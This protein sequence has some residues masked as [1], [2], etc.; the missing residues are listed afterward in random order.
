MTLAPAHPLDALAAQIRLCRN[1]DLVL[2]RTH[3]VPGEGHPTARIVFVGEGPGQVEDQTGRPFVGPAGQFLEE[4]L[5]EIGLRRT[6]VFIA[7]VTKCRPPNNRDPLPDEIEACAPWLRA[8]LAIIRP[9][10]VCPLGRFAAQTLLD[11]HLAIGKAHG[12][13]IEKDGILFIPLYHPAAALH[14]QSL[15]DTCLADIR[16]VRQLLETHGLWPA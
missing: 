16:T 5:T 4:L 14:Q 3:A 11:P 12:Q 6:D 8:Q 7:N 1:C 2:R 13:P 15:R 10:V 9:R